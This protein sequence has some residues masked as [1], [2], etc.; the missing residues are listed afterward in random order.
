MQKF[1]AVEG[2]RGWMAWWVVLV[3]ALH[4]SG[5]EKT[6][7][8]SI[9]SLA[10]NGE[11]AVQVFMIVSGFVIA[12]LITGRAEAYPVYIIRR[13]FRLAPL[14]LAILVVAVLTRD[15]YAAAYVQNPWAA[16]PALRASRMAQEEAHWL[17]HALLHV[18]LLHG[19]PP[20]NILQYSSTA[21]LAPAW[22]LSLEWQFYLLAPII[23]S[24]MNRWSRAPVVLLIIALA[25][26]SMI[27]KW[28]VP[29]FLPLAMM[30]FMIGV[31]SRQL[32][33]GHVSWVALVTTAISIGAYVIQQE[34][35][36]I[37][38]VIVVVCVW[39]F[40]FMVV[41]RESGLISFKSVVF[42]FI[43]KVFA[44]NRIVT[45]VGRV[46]YSTYLVHVVVFAVV[47]GGGIRVGDA[48]NH[49]Y[50]VILTLLAVLLTVPISLLLYK[51]IERP[52]ISLGNKLL[53]RFAIKVR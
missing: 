47:I 30:F 24:G 37:R 27:F 33:D 51:Y 5:L 34:L 20:D 19:V 49:L 22:S 52:G 35:W 43:S 41:C 46:S 29:S 6:L 40:F 44:L 21:F 25:A 2:L 8:S 16:E 7:P 38:N 23:V 11:M 26:L 10:T 14:F 31:A 50:V 42:D 17:T 32:L 9:K 3:H 12:H 39:A 36:Q 53:A 45:L 1:E 13:Y 15:L 18:S 48:S 4:V 28:Q